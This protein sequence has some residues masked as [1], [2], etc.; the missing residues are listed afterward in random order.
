MLPDVAGCNISNNRLN[1]T[2]H[3][4][5]YPN[6][7]KLDGVNRMTI[8]SLKDFLGGSVHHFIESPESRREYDYIDS[9]K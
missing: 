7:C 8:P 1:T 3:D 6:Y 9:V 2:T 5:S 4:W